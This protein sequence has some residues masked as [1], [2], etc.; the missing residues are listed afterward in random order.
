MQTAFKKDHEM[1]IGATADNHITDEKPARRLDENYLETCMGK[2]N[3]FLERCKAFG[4]LPLAAGDVFDSS[5]V[6]HDVVSR[7]IDS[8]IE[9]KSPRIVCVRGQH[10]MR[11][12]SNVDM[13]N[14]PMQVLKSS[15]VAQV[16][17][18]TMV[19]E[20]G[21]NVHIF[22][23]SFGEPVVELNPKD[24]KPK[25]KWILLIH[26]AMSN[27]RENFETD[28]ARI[29]QRQ[30]P[31]FDLIISGDNHKQFTL[32]DKGTGNWLINP[33]SMMRKTTAQFEHEPAVYFWDSGSPT[34]M[35]REPIPVA[36][37]ET[38]FNVDK[39]IESKQSNSEMV[40]FIRN[41]REARDI[42]GLDY[43]ENLRDRMKQDKS[44]AE[45]VRC[46]EGWLRDY[47]Q[48]NKGA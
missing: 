12:H 29:F 41:V 48:L 5:K 28:Q 26:R 1:I 43:V 24:K 32:Q 22:G 35:V 38:V 44:D 8:L 40:E 36:P 37:I 39:I 14:T 17:T 3:F 15:G 33:G 11:Y 16:I 2:F 20:I 30:Y 21:Y 10:E 27:S 34:R 6:G 18:Y 42:Q 31:H 4:A 7:V 19:R 46:V 23:S 9:C 47:N 13:R 25:D 45:I